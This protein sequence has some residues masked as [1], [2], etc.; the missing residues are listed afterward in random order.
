MD[1]FSSP[2]S[3]F[4]FQFQF[5]ESREVKRISHTRK[6]RKKILSSKMFSSESFE[7]KI[8]GQLRS[9]G[10]GAF[11]HWKFGNV[12]VSMF[13]FHN[14]NKAGRTFHRVREVYR[15]INTSNK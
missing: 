3:G 13:K 2:L 4:S 15:L 1:I 8:W 10:S 7:R 14:K 9:S 11:G 5:S 6:K 12:G